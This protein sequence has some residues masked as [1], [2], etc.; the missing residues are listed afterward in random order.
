MKPYRSS[1]DGPGSPASDGF[2]SKLWEVVLL[3][4]PQAVLPLM[5]ILGGGVFLVLYG[6]CTRSINPDEF[7][8][9]QVDVSLPLLTG[10]SGIH[11]NIYQTGTY[12]L[13]PGCE[14][15]IHFPR[16]VRAVTFHARGTTTDARERFVR[17]EEAA[18]IQTSDGFFINLDVSILYRVTDPYRVVKEFGAGALYEQNGIVLQAEPT[19]KATMGTLTPEDFFHSLRRVAKQEEARDKFNEFLIPRGLKVEHVLIRYPQYHE[20]VQARIEAR[21]IQEQTKLKNVEEAKLAQ[22]QADLKQV[23]MQGEASAAIKLMEGSN[24]VTR[25]AA[26]ME[27]YERKRKSEAN[28]LTALAEAEKQKLI[29]DAYQGSGSER[30]VGLE[31][32]KVLA[33]LETIVLQSGGEGGFNPLD[34]DRLLR[35]LKVTKT[36]AK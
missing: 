19:L 3:F 28:R 15:F 20:A 5:I 32:A 9:R 17:F 13:I 10:P 7:A 1:A 11:S 4:R 22:A 16:S 24:S 12:W 30:L 23:Q 18:H 6:L 29:N 21:N 34:L 31:W 8:V 14:K 25:L 33:G 2:W 35:Q 36:E 26:Q 27:A